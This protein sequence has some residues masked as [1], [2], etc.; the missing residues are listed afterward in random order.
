M[1]TTKQTQEAFRFFQEHAGYCV[2]QRAAGALRLAHAEHAAKAAGVVFVWE[3]EPDADLSYLEQTDERGRYLFSQGERERDH[4]V[5]WC[6][7]VIPCEEHGVDCPHAQF[8]ASLG[9]IVDA[10]RNYRRVVEA[11]L[12]L[13]S[14]SDLS[15]VSPSAVGEG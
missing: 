10:D 13:E 1:Q 9:N 6:R 14:L 11:E 5:M 2:G 12:A 15:S 4:E 7:A 3:D 8:L